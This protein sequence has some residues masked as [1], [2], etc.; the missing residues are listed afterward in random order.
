MKRK[1][2]ER[3]EKEMWSRAR[4]NDRIRGFTGEGCRCEEEWETL[5]RAK[6]FMVND[7]DTKSMKSGIFG[8][9]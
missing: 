5:S 1:S 9:L 6:W 4:D 8:P 7:R 3:Y 2:Y